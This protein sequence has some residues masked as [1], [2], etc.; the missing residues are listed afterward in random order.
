MFIFG[1]TYTFYISLKSHHI[2]RCKANFYGDDCS[3]YL[4]DDFD[5][6]FAS[7]SELEALNEPSMFDLKNA[8]KE[9]GEKILNVSLA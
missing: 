6:M 2:F 9:V 1:Y 3:S 5:E 4:P 7:G 8:I